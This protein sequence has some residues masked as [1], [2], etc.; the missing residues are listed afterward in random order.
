MIQQGA[1][2]HESPEPAAIIGRE[3]TKR[4]MPV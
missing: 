1:M 3:F 4:R 2:V